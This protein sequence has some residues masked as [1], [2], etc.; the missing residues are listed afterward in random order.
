MNSSV[1]TYGGQGGS[2][3]HQVNESQLPLTGISLEL[4][5]LIAIL[6]IGIGLTIYLNER[7][8]KEHK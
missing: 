8:I 5:I 2:I 7:V 4:I 3:A 1:E 6:I